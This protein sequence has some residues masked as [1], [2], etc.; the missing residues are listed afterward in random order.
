MLQRQEQSFRGDQVPI[1]QA[2][3][4]F[5][6]NGSTQ[7]RAAGPRHRSDLSTNARYTPYPRIPSW[8]QDDPRRRPQQHSY[9]CENAQA[10]HYQN[11]Q[12]NTMM[13][14]FNGWHTPTAANQVFFPG[15]HHHH[16]HF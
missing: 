10:M 12:H 9:E 3:R 1:T 15:H 11:N 2:Q 14:Q 16:H 5:N 7:V 6:A 4:P 8:H 13:R